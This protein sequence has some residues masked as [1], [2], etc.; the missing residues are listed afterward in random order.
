MRQSRS[1]RRPW[2]RS[3]E[4]CLGLPYRGGLRGSRRP[5]PR[6]CRARALPGHGI[7]TRARGSRLHAPPECV[8][9]RRLARFWRAEPLRWPMRSSPSLEQCGGLLPCE[10]QFARN[11]TAIRSSGD[12]PE[13]A[14]RTRRRV[15]R[16]SPP[17][18]CHQLRSIARGTPDG[19]TIS[20]A[21]RSVW[22]LLRVQP[23]R[24]ARADARRAPRRHCREECTPRRA[25][26]FDF[27]QAISS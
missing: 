22:A 10:R 5:R 13:S 23:E 1:F 27:G 9:G 15:R 4:R 24:D 8:C 7:A 2:H 14:D 12:E 17:D 16:A 6:G 19:A 3:V 26:T 21:R 11:V 20:G 25:Y 18:A